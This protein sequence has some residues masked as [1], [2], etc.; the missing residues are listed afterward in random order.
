MNEKPFP[1]S[2]LPRWLYRQGREH[3]VKLTRALPGYP[4][5]VLA[6]F[7]HDLGTC[8]RSLADLPRGLE[9]CVKS[10]SG[11]PLAHRWSNAAEMVRGGATLAEAL[12][13]AYDRLPPF[14]L[15]VVR[16]GERSG[17]LDDAFAFLE[18]HC[19]LLAGPA[20]SI[21][22]AWLYPLVI[23]LIGSVLRVLIVMVMGSPLVGLGLAMTEFF[24]WLQ[25]LLIVFVATLPPIR[26]LVDEMRLN[27][28]FLGDLEKEIAL[29]RF[30][31]VLALMYT[32]GE[33]RVELMIRTAAETVTNR[34][35]KADLLRAAKA[36]EDQASIPD[37]FGQ[38]RFL[39]ADQ[40]GTIEA[41]E[42][43]GT[44]ELAFDQISTDTG[45]RV[46]HKFAIITPILTRLVMAFVV[47]SI[48]AT[49]MSLFL[50]GE[51]S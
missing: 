3:V 8:I 2:E 12:A 7:S 27:A 23:L 25:L 29:N 42:M 10:L 26:V 22:K 18:S 51:V 28:P 37:A 1:E 6:R 46:I 36:I 16:A 24:G 31:R 17:R 19:K 45:E 14:Y 41:G 32:V 34:A 39:T 35:A 49:L 21:R 47:F 5:Q 20:S 4:Y 11:T 9:L 44:L 40:K 48:L 13:P 15:P 43:S 50:N 33:H 30:F 38:V